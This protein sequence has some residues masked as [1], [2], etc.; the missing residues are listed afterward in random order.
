MRRDAAITIQVSALRRIL[1]GVLVLVALLAL[2]SFAWSQRDRVGGIFLRGLAAQADPNTY[3]A[4]ALTGGQVY[5]GKL[6]SGG[7]DVLLLT[8]I[9]YLSGPTDANPRGQLIK[10][11]SEVHGPEEP[12]IIPASQVLFIENL[13]P[14]SEVVQAI[15]RFRAGEVAPPI[16]PQPVVAPTPTPTPRPSPTR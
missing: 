7:S 4:V 10:R 3:Q 2:F 11:G 1:L 13:R 16:P 5:F 9:Y 14:E 12:M 8:D 15:G 6:S